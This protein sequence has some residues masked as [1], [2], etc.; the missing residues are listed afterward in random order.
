M[1][2]IISPAKQMRIVDD[3]YSEVQTKPRFQK[4][5]NSLI[6][7]LQK[8]SYQEYKTMM[9]CSDKIA[10]PAYENIQNYDWNGQKSPA[11]LS[12]NG[13]QYQYMAPEVH[14]MIFNHID[15]KCKQ[16]STVPCIHFGKIS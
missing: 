9:K 15:W 12:Y 3:F 5:A 7:S 1:N 4:E 16:N 10:L 14:S 8:L 6:K 2:I 11:I 13:I